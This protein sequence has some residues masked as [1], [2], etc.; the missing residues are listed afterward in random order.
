MIVI[1]S[2]CVP[3]DDNDDKV[4]DVEPR[5]GAIMNNRIR[6]QFACTMFFLRHRLLC[7]LSHSLCLLNEL[8]SPIIGF[9]AI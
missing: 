1:Q 3:H 9:I 5:T 4:F 2:A 8:C 7:S 6:E